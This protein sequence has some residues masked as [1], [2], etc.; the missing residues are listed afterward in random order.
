VIQGAAERCHGQL[1]GQGF[2]L[3]VLVAQSGKGAG[4]PKNFA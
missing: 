4:Q 2:G 3:V 1:I